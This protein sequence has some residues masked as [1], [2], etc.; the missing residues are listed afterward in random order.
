MRLIGRESLREVSREA[1]SRQWVIHW[2]SELA[3]AHWKRPND[4][5]QQ[6]PKCVQR[7]DGS[8]AFP[9]KGGPVAIATV[10]HFPLGIALILGTTTI[11]EKS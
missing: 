6:F 8:F 2:T 10:F 5:L 7:P 3:N 4:V 1:T 9:V 11:V